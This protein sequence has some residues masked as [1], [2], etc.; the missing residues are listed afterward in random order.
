MA[1]DVNQD[2]A[3]E[4]PRSLKA[5][6][7]DYVKLAADV[8]S[9]V[10]DLRDNPTR[11]DWFSAGCR[12]MGTGLGWWQEKSKI[13]SRG[14]YDY[15]TD[16]E[17]KRRGEAW[18][19][20]PGEY[21]MLVLDTV[22]KLRV[23]EEWLDSDTSTPYVCLANL[24]SEVVGWAASAENAPLSGPYYK[25]AREEETYAELGKLAWAKLGSKHAMFDGDHLLIDPLHNGD[26]IA[27]TMQMDDMLRRVQRYLK[28][29]INRSY[30]LTGAPGTGKSVATRWL[31]GV[32]G[33]TSVRVNVGVL[34]ENASVV[35][36]LTRALRILKPDVLILDDLDRVEVDAEVLSFLE[37]ARQ[38]CRLVVATANHPSALSGACLRPGRLDE[39]IQFECL[40]RVVVDQLLGEFADLA[41]DVADLPAAYVV[42]FANRC[43]VLGREEA[44]AGLDTL[45]DRAEE[46]SEDSD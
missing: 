21:K 42:E 16:D 8:A 20:F 44:Q 28:A 19:E 9:I 6:I 5:R 29:K 40:D 22:K 31:I 12:A 46:T 36:S 24:G 30:L 33:M 2:L 37:M 23:A 10:M 15:F 4:R 45:R 43:K 13:P 34:N 1:S 25:S 41:E 3:P 32:L 11:M 18:T 27:A 26:G 17:Y 38:M 14:V 35:G 39:L 7:V